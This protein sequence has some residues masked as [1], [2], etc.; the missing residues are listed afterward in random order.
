MRKMLLLL[1]IPTLLLAFYPGKPLETKVLI[2]YQKAGKVES[3]V[4]PLAKV[5]S[6][7]SSI[8][9]T[10]GVIV[11]KIHLW[12]IQWQPPSIRP[13]ALYNV[14][15]ELWGPAWQV[16]TGHLNLPPVWQ[17]IANHNVSINVKVA[18]IDTGVRDIPPLNVDVNEGIAT[19]GLVDILNQTGYCN[20]TGYITFDSN[21]TFLNGLLLSY[22]ATENMTLSGITFKYCLYYETVDWFN[23]GTNDTV[24]FI[25]AVNPTDDIV[26]HG[27]FVTSQINGIVKALGLVTGVE[28]KIQVIPIKADALAIVL[29]NTT[30]ANLNAS[31]C[32][33]NTTWNH[34]ILDGGFFSDPDL[35]IAAYYVSQLAK[36]DKNLK[37]VNM[38]LGGWGTKDDVET[39]CNYTVEVMAGAGLRVVVAA[40]NEGRNIDIMNSY[41]YY[42]YPA[43]CPSA[44][45]VSALTNA[46]TL[47]SF[48]NY[49]S[50]IKFTAPGM[51]NTGI[52]PY[53]SI[54]GDIYAYF[55]ID[56]YRDETDGYLI[57]MSSGTSYASPLVAGS[58][59]LAIALGA[60]DPVSALA[61]SATDLFTQGVDVYSGYGE[62]NLA[63]LAENLGYELT[64][65]NTF[66][67]IT[68]MLEP[69]TVTVT[70]RPGETTMAAV[71]VT[72]NPP[73]LATVVVGNSTTTVE[74][75]GTVL[76]SIMINN[77]TTSTF[78]LTAI[79]GTVSATTVLQAIVKIQTAL[80]WL[81]TLAVAAVAALLLRRRK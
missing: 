50:V 70:G 22:G 54:I 15:G 51:R 56:L 72:V 57:A 41:G 74:G 69:K 35:M 38:S 62:P 8:Q 32:I 53:P 59:A 44:I 11:K 3:T 78:T 34:R 75:Y 36:N 77:E 48:S 81:P 1:L 63:K 33:S 5:E 26:G 23:N 31:A 73:V 13:E 27:T 19:T 47:A 61:N 20:D 55:G 43:N 45:P 29:V 71:G 79:V 30:C 4:V 25:Q 17:Y 67:T 58:V 24:I 40:G 64:T 65:T 42:N 37:V 49:G 76:L 18:V 16:D 28:P 2:I 68:F 46:Y 66:T 7:I 6:T 21:T 10:G 14:G 12:R 52:Y 9:A 80:P 39:Q 60:Q